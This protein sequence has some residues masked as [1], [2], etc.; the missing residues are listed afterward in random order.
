MV[1]VYKEPCIPFGGPGRRE[2]SASC[3]K[4][5][6][7]GQAGLVQNKWPCQITG[8]KLSNFN[9]LTVQRKDRTW[10]PLVKASGF[11]QNGRKDAFGHVL[12]AFKGNGPPQ[13]VCILG[14]RCDRIGEVTM[15]TLAPCLSG[16]G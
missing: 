16:C 6:G 11:K 12:V 3:A 7:V 13:N 8:P 9:Q 10:I 4:Q 5:P 1:L 14:P 15:Y 2:R